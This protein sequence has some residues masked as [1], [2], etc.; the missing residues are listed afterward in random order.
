MHE[1]IRMPEQTQGLIHCV[2][3]AG[4]E[5]LPEQNPDRLRIHCEI[6]YEPHMLPEPGTSGSGSASQTIT[7]GRTNADYFNVLST[8][9]L[10]VWHPIRRTFRAAACFVVCCS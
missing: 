7:S 5:Q 8:C 1:V 2:K 4:I 9:A 6:E 10:E 3:V